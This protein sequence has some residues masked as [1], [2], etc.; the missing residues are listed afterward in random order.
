MIAV[1]KSVKLLLIYDINGT[2]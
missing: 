1:T 2:R